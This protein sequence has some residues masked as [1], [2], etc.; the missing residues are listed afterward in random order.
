MPVLPLPALILFG[1]LSGVVVVEAGGAV[2]PVRGTEL[3]TSW[4]GLLRPNPVDPVHDPWP[5]LLLLAGV[6]ALIASW[7]LAVRALRA[8][9][10]TWR[11]SC[12]LG[13]TWSLPLALGPPM[14]S[15]DVFSYAAQGLMLTRG[16]DPYHS[17]PGALGATV[18]TATV[19]PR[20]RSTPSPYGP[21]AAYVERAATS[22]TGG[23][24]L[25]TVLLLR[26]IAM[27]SLVAIGV[28]A[29]RL[30]APRLRASALLLTVANPLLLLQGLSAVHFE[31]LMGALVLGSLVA[32]A[33]SRP[34]WAVLLA[35]GASAVKFPGVE[36]GL[37]VAVTFA[38][39][40]A[41][42]ILDLRE[43][44]VGSV[45]ARLG[46]ALRRPLHSVQGRLFGYAAL[47]TGAWLVLARLV[48][49]GWG[50]ISALGTPGQGHTP[51]APTQLLAGAVGWPLQLAGLASLARITT[52]ARLLGLGTAVG[53][54]LHL[55]TSATRRPL[56]VTVGLSLLAGGL[57]APVLY[58]WYLL[59]G[60]LVI[61]TFVEDEARSWLVGLCAVGVLLNLPGMAPLTIGLVA[62]SIG[63]IAISAAA[64]GAWL[65]RV[66]RV[67]DMAQQAEACQLKPVSSRR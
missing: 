49:D 51:L 39:R 17:G 52:L 31:V 36:P 10:L 54:A 64:R 23:D 9:R 8:H 45:Q 44:A 59:W 65:L 12:A 22:L 61:A 20:W 53:I 15:N 35:C 57:L 16:L 41:R 55:L 40:P 21:L 6:L 30:A 63:L 26:L 25:T 33:R 43:P 58:P 34:V 5:G 11:G 18:A 27:L 29:Y 7:L 24:V 4:L 48:P 14:L 38:V 67:V 56:V 19:D 32:A 37:A 42:R 46:A 3:P 47:I 50:W 2:G 66:R 1:V 62:T 28:F 13:A 60:A